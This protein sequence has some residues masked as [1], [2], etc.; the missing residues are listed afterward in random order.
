[1]ATHSVKQENRGEGKDEDDEEEEEKKRGVVGGPTS[2]SRASLL[3]LQAFCRLQRLER[4]CSLCSI[5][6]SGFGPIDLLLFLPEQLPG[7]LGVTPLL[8]CL[9][10]LAAISR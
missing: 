2:C 6:G 9:L 1:L 4:S 5:P 10:R 3:C 8:L 7:E